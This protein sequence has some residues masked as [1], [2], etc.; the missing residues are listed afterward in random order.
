MHITSE[1]WGSHGCCSQPAL[2]HA[3]LAAAGSDSLAQSMCAC[4]TSATGFLHADLLIWGLLQRQPL[5]NPLEW[6]MA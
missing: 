3:N 4:R 6:S 1:C 5:H 2:Q